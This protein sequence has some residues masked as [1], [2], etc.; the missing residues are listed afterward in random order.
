MKMEI[1]EKV[2]QRM[3]GILQTDQLQELKMAMII[4]ME[5]YEIQK[6]HTELSTEVVGNWEYCRRFLQNMVV[7]GKSPGTVADYQSHLKILLADVQICQY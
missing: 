4:C 2:V 7:T 3:S 6:E 5:G 1:I